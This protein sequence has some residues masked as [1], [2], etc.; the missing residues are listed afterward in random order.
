[1]SLVA[2]TA[3]FIFFLIYFVEANPVFP[4]EMP[5]SPDRPNIV[6]LMVDD[7]GYGDILSYGNPTQEWNEVDQMIKEGTRFTH[8]YSADSMCSPSRAAFMTGRL[9]V[10]L[11]ITGGARVFLPQDMGGLPQAEPTIAEMLKGAGY[12]T[13]MIGKWHLGINQHNAT[14]GAYLPSKRG[15]DFVGLNLPFTNTWQCDTT[16]EYFEEGPDRNWCFL[17]NGDEIVQQPIKFEHLTEDLVNDWHRFLEERM[18]TDQHKRPFF[19]YFSFPH[20]HSTQFANE[21][22]KH[23]SNRG[24]FGDNVNEMAWAV[25]Q[26]MDS[27]KKHNIHRNTLVVF[28]SDHGPHQ[29]LCN[30]GGS[31]AGLKGG[32]SNSYEGGFRIPFVTW[33]PG[34]VQAGVVSPEVIWSLD[35]YPTFRRLAYGQNQF[36]F[37][38]R[39]LD[40]TDVWPELQGYSASRRNNYNDVKHFLNESLSKRRP[41]YFYCNKNLMAIRYGDYKVHFMTS[42]IFKNFSMDPKLEEFCPGGKPKDDWYVSQTCP[43]RQLIKHNPPLVYNL[44][45]DPYELYHLPSESD[46]SKEMIKKAFELKHRHQ[47]TVQVVDQQLGKFNPNL[48]PCC[49]TDC[50]CDK[51]TPELEVVKRRA[52]T[53]WPSH[54]PRN[55]TIGNG[56]SIY[57][58]VAT[59]VNHHYRRSLLVN[60]DSLERYIEAKLPLPFD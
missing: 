55:K 12:Y 49:G 27:L 46:I 34:T 53:K 4:D 20:V 11:G 45:A 41:I 24:L 48:I 25:G 18:A 54:L 14:D 23:S 37:D 60:D 38:A 40:G 43:E 29:E 3:I 19:F 33:M 44:V 13:G 58:F 42:P 15:F 16:K 9:P 47:K 6:V 56:R 59:H 1:M 32:K 39:H 52:F 35:L 31:T 28:M 2:A 5:P 7:L 21:F 10:R 22:F 57:E 8:A 36:K 50:S 30:N 26:V 51:L 17:Y